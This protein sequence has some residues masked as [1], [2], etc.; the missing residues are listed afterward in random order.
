MQ[1]SIVFPVLVVALAVVLFTPESVQGWRRRRFR[2]FVRKAYTAYKV[3][4]AVGKR[5]A[6]LRETDLQTVAESVGASCPQ[7]ADQVAAVLAAK[8]EELDANGDGSL[9]GE[10]LDNF[11]AFLGK[12]F[13]P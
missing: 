3:Y 11:N 1:R 7:S 5:G 8:L 12:L 13:S 9:T 2:R 10:E 6:E 4:Q